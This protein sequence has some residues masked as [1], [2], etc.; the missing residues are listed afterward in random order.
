MATYGLP[1]FL[2]RNAIPDAGGS[3]EL[4]QV[5]PDSHCTPGFWVSMAALARMKNKK[6]SE[7][8]IPCPSHQNYSRAIRLPA[9]LGEADNYQH[10]R[11]NEGLNYS[12]L[13]LLESSEATDE[14]TWN[15]NGCIRELC[16]GLGV[17]RFEKKLCEVV[18]DLHDNI[19]SHGKSTG[20]S[21]AQ[22]WKKPYCEG[23][24]LF[25]FALADCGIGFLGELRRVGLD[26]SDDQ[27]AIDWCIQR[28]NSSKLVCEKN[29]DGWSQRLPPDIMGN[30]M[31]GMGKVRESDNNHQGLGLAKLVDL[32]TAYRGKLWLC[33][34][35]S[36]LVKGDGSKPYTAPRFSWQGVTLACRFDTSV[37]RHNQ[38]VEEDDD[39]TAGLIKLLGD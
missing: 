6:Y 2:G 34:G 23:D 20:F 17:D 18:G 9:A 29:D 3:C 32:V 35:N 16:S 37:I 28:G 39:I 33:S 5:Y 25:E 22:R 8:S 38:D 27:S 4:W 10:V 36:M 15:V 11:R 7:L 1:E 13:V 31:P 26:I 30:P 24:Y 12:G 19:W 14:A 21:M